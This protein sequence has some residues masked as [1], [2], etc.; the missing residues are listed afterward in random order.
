MFCSWGGTH[1]RFPVSLT[2]HAGSA[3]LRPLEALAGTAFTFGDQRMPACLS[4]LRPPRRGCL[5][6]PSLPC[7]ASS[8]PFEVVARRMTCRGVCRRSSDV[9]AAP[10]YRRP[11]RRPA[12]GRQ[13]WQVA[14]PWACP[15]LPRLVGRPGRA[16]D[17]C[18]LAKLADPTLLTGRMRRMLTNRMPS[19]PRT[20]CSGGL[21]GK[22]CAD[23]CTGELRM[24]MARE[25]G[26]QGRNHERNN[27]VS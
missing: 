8:A 7:A 4:R 27:C 10:P 9:S 19:Q 3:R 5:A 20:R 24:P 22:A 18:L 11:P 23:G 1:E 15:A 2:T 26:R 13:R 17:R 14:A 16:R 21:N 25:T 6:T 12:S